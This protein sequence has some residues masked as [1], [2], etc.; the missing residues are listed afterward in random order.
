MGVP[1]PDG[2]RVATWLGTGGVR[3]YPLGGGEP[4]DVPGASPVELPVQWRADGLDLYL[5]RQSL[6]GRFR[7]YEV[8][9]ATGRRA[10][11]KELRMADPAGAWIDFFRMTPNGEAYAYNS[12]NALSTLYLA[13]GLR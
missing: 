6:L 11:W 8:D 10:Q 5:G 2:S 7:I 12:S 1:S 9:L 4:R 3:I 13:E